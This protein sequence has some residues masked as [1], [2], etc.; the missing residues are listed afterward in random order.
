MSVSVGLCHVSVRF[1]LRSGNVQYAIS[2]QTFT[3][4]ITFH[5]FFSIFSFDLASYIFFFF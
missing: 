3:K 1:T 4:V 2:T 5:I